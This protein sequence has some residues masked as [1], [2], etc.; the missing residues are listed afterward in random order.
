MMFSKLFKK[1]IEFFSKKNRNIKEK[2]FRFYAFSND[3]YLLCLVL[4]I[5]LL[6]IFLFFKIYILAVFNVFSCFIFTLNLILNRKGK[7]KA[8]YHIALVEITIHATLATVC[9]GWESNFC[10]YSIG[11]CSVI[12]FSTFL[13]FREKMFEIFFTTVLYIITFI[14]VM[15]FSPVYAVDSSIIEAIGLLNISMMI[16]LLTFIFHT[17]YETTDI[18]N[19]K[20]KEA[21]EIDGLTGAYNRRFFNEYLE[22]EA[23]RMLNQI[24]YNSEARYNINFAIAIIDIDDFKKVNDTYGHIAG[25]DVLT[26]I[27]EII[28]RVSFSRDLVCRFGGEE[29]VILFTKTSKEGAIKA[30]E[31]IR[32]EVETHNFYINDNVKNV[33][34]TVSI[35]FASF[36]DEKCS[37]EVEKV[38]KLADDRLYEAKTHGKNMVVYEKLEM[39]GVS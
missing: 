17:F 34:V 1:G 5:A 29:F 12:M 37:W 8:A 18:L 26:Q 2:D 4:H 10:F 28:K 20:L 16:P 35:G 27:V 13:S 25:D 38:L 36:D 7:L 23:K 14:H 11:I 33:H 9:L 19:K 30:S 24:I 15:S 31:K 22:I 3:L 39:E 21:A 32:R 6:I